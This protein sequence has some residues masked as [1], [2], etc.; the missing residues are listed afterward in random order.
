MKKYTVQVL[1]KIKR[2]EEAE[3]RVEARTPGEALRKVERAVQTLEK[4]GIR[5]PGTQ[6]VIRHKDFIEA[7]YGE[8][9][10]EELDIDDVE[11]L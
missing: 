1:R 7:G 4:G 5:K 2:D 8:E 6:V 11:E 3:V 9:E 10:Y